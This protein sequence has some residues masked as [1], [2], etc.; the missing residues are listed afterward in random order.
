MAATLQINKRH[1]NYTSLIKFS[2]YQN[3]VTFKNLAT[4]NRFCDQ[5]YYFKSQLQNFA[6][7]SNCI[8]RIKYSYFRNVSSDNYSKDSSSQKQPEH[9]GLIMP[10]NDKQKQPE[11]KII[12]N[13]QLKPPP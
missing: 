5:I 3:L 2:S 6:R 9:V 13:H 4:I 8:R 12:K 1:E 7:V 10:N 11:L